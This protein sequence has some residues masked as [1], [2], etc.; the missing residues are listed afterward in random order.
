[1]NNSENKTPIFVLIGS[2]GVGKS[3]IVKKISSNTLLETLQIVTYTSRAP[4]N[5]EI[6]GI[7]YNFT[8][9]E[10]FCQLIE[11]NELL[12]WK[13]F[14]GNFYGTLKNQ[15]NHPKA[16]ALIMAT[17]VPG[18]IWLK[19]HFGSRLF[20]IKI[21]VSDSQELNRRLGSRKSTQEE[22]KTRLDADKIQI[23]MLAKSKTTIDLTIDNLNLD[24]SIQMLTQFITTKLK[25]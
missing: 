14:N 17:D 6:D 15:F 20:I 2:S 9:K 19:N 16:K 18:A 4:R 11:R 12:E 3:T 23:D 22:L 7:D 1:M 8:T 13:L 24:D 21:V 10:A 25:S 5:I